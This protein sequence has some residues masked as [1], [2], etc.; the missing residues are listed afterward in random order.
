MVLLKVFVPAFFASV[1]AANAM[2]Q[3]QFVTDAP[4][5][6]DHEPNGLVHDAQ[7]RKDAAVFEARKEVNG[8]LGPTY[9]AQACAECHQNP[10]TGGISQVTELR[11][12]SFSNGVFIDAPG[13][14]L[15]QSRAI[16]PAIQERLPDIA[17]V[18]AFRT[19]PLGR[20]KTISP[21]QDIPKRI[22]RLVREWAGIA[23]DRELGQALLDLRAHFDRW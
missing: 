3:S 20:R 16:D 12:G 2:M 10:V 13:G 18:R 5:G 14:S 8:G 7:F 6:F 9:N 19:R 15:I 21:V 4:A 11:A 17:T 22:K 23:H 1:L